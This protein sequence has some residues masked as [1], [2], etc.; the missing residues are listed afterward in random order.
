MSLG[1]RKAELKVNILCF[2]QFQY[3]ARCYFVYIIHLMN[4]WIISWVA[5]RERLFDHLHRYP[6]TCRDLIVELDKL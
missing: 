1:K 4:F 2:S 6:R 5:D 3:I